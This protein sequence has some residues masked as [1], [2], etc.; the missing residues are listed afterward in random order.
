M[1][2]DQPG[3]YQ[4]PARIEGG[5]VVIIGGKVGLGPHPLDDGPVPDECRILDDMDVGLSSRGP[6][7]RELTDVAKDRH[8]QSVISSEAKDLVSGTW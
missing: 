5:Q 1:A 2:I 8:Q 4:P 3:N 6:A 7:G